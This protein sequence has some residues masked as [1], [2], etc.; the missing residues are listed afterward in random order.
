M[1]RVFPCVGLF[2]I[3]LAMAAASPLQGQ[4]ENLSRQSVVERMKPY[5]GEHVDGV[6]TSTLTGKVMCGY[7]GWFTAEGDGAHMGW[8]HYA[9]HHRTLAPGHCTFDLWPDMSE[10]TAAEKY[11]TSFQHADGSPAYLFSPC[12]RATVLRHFSWMQNH[13][14]DGVFLQRFG[15]SLRDPRL[16]NQRNMVTANVQAGANCHGRTWAMMYDLSGLRS[17][18][19]A[20]V[21]VE[22]WKLLVDRIQIR[23]DK[24]YLH[25][26]GKPLVAI[27]GVGFNDHRAYSLEACEQ[28]VRFLKD[29]PHY[30]GNTVMLGVPTG[31]RTLTRDAVP[32]ERLHAIIRQTDI[33]SPWTVGRYRDPASARRHAQQCAKADIAWCEEQKLDYLPVVFPGFSWHNLMK[34]RGRQTALGE[35]PRLAGRFFWSQAAALKNAG[36]TMLY[37]AMFDEIDEGT[38]IFKC[39]NNPPVG[40]SPFLTYEGLPTDYYL[41][42]AGEAGRLLRSSGE[43]PEEMPVREKPPV[44]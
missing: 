25:H 14:I 27:W 44:Q 4:E 12:N 24:A 3:L 18:E 13:G 1:K 33:V 32:E 10:M 41:W 31:W 37:V 42:L 35:I 38:A 36:A 23:R 20:S 26:R 39:T 8:H 17:E 9:E 28:L 16:L 15:V 11:R 19:I 40:E 22:D 30:G 29:D 7:Q 5:E 21:V 2:A 6:D 34:T 43:A